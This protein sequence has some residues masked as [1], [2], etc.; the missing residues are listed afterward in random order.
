MDVMGRLVGKEGETTKDRLGLRYRTLLPV[1]CE[2]ISGSR[3]G[4]PNSAV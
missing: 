4:E 2:L 1:T 3:E